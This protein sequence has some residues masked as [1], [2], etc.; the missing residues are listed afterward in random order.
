MKYIF[1]L[2]TALLVCGLV[3]YPSIPLFSSLGAE[4]SS[5]LVIPT[6]NPEH[7]RF[8]KGEYSQCQ[9][10]QG[11]REMYDTK[12]HHMFK[13]HYQRALESTT[14]YNL[15]DPAYDEIRAEQWFRQHPKETR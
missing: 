4:A 11:T 2:F 1:V 14:L 15:P 9:F 12:C 10:V 8:G 3:M 13:K 6:P 5:S 7:Y